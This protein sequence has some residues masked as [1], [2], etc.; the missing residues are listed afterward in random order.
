MTDGGTQNTL[1]LSDSKGTVK[2]STAAIPTTTSS[3]LAPNSL[4][5]GN[6][7]DIP[8]NNNPNL[9]CP[10]MNSRR[11]NAFLSH[12]F[13]ESLDPRLIKSDFY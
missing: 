7:L 8:Q 13:I 3:T 5:A 1:L 6:H 11:G 12:H 4:S 9:L 10:D 2:E